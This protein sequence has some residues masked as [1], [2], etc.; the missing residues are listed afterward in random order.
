MATE[1]TTDLPI[2]GRLQCPVEFYQF[3]LGRF[4]TLEG[5]LGHLEKTVT[6]NVGE[7]KG[8][9][10]MMSVAAWV[11]TTVIALFAASQNVRVTLVDRPMPPAKHS[12][13]SL[14][15]R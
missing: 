5:K 7:R 9:F 13:A 11:V 3:C 10:R 15:P 12:P 1:S 8:H 4:E 6:S 2:E 14:A